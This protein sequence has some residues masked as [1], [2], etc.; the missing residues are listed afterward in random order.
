MEFRRWTNDLK[1]ASGCNP[2]NVA[3]C[4]WIEPELNPISRAATSQCS[5]NLTGNAALHLVEEVYKQT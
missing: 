5:G 3:S 1:G 4:D 2:A